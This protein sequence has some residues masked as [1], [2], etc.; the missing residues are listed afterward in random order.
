MFGRCKLTALIALLALAAAGCGGGDK[1]KPSLPPAT[2]AKLNERLDTVERQLNVGGGACAD[3]V[4]NTRPVIENDLGNLPDSVDPDARKA[5][6]ESFDRLF[7]L[8][9]EQCDTSTEPAPTT[10]QETQT[11][12]TQTQETQ[13]QETQTQETQTQETV[14]TAPEKPNKP[15][16]PKGGGGKDGGGGGG[17]N[18]GS[19]FEGGGD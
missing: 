3:I 12:E 9:D 18:G 10:T 5:L 13:T 16:K 2:V 4:N 7:Q 6:N 15:E 17:G 11:Q 1:P 19:S 8:V 14:P